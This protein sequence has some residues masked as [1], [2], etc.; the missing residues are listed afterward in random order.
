MLDANEDIKNSQLARMLRHPDLDM[1]EAFKSR[2]NTEGLATFF[3]IK[4]NRWFM[5]IC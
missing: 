2:S 1:K 4:T 3:W 5:G